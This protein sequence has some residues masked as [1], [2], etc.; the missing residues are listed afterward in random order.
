[1]KDSFNLT[2]E[3]TTLPC[4]VIFT[5]VAGTG[6][7]YRL[8]QLAKHYTDMLQAVDADQMGKTLVQTLSWR[9]VIALVF[10]HK[11]KQGQELLKVA[12]IVAN[13]F[14]QYKAMVNDREENL[15]QTAW[16]T[17][18]KYAHTDKQSAYQQSIQA[19]FAK[20][21]SSHWYLLS[22]SLPLL[23][24]LQIQLDN[25]LNSVASC[26][27]HE[28]CRYVM[29]SFHQAYGYDEFVEGI[30]PSI[31][32]DGK[33]HYGIQA[34][35]FVRLCEQAQQDPTHRYAMLI[36]EIN[37]ANV[38][39]VFGEL[40]S[41][42]EPSKRIGQPQAMQVNLAYSGRLFGVPNNVDIYATMNVQDR[43]LIAL[44]TA[45]RRR[46]EFVELLP[47]SQQLPCIDNAYD[48]QSI[49][50]AKILDGLNIRLLQHVGEQS[51]LGQAYFYGIDSVDKLLVVMVKQVLPQLLTD[52][53]YAQLTQ[54]LNLSKV[55]WL[56][57]TVDIIRDK[58]T[59]QHQ[60]ELSQNGFFNEFNESSLHIHPEITKTISWLTNVSQQNLA[61]KHK[62]KFLQSVTWQ[63]LYP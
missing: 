8:Q 21:S 24:D 7:T 2:A 1:M 56:V 44:D 55:P 13:P 12:D 20:D 32:D 15:E 4:N 14:F 3:L 11:L 47:N 54:V 52:L 37:R 39:Q 53:S 23:T 35:A 61:K 42:I 57:P 49:D 9:E 48:H 10:L 33:M 18:G 22:D 41:L 31:D 34:G 58:I 45:L 16:T 51:L 62:G 5:G 27:Q 6:K 60:S 38:V 40:L 30:R 17:L 46:F 63:S 50:L 26:H 59:N 25:Y 28:R 19:Y 29:V 43:S 36:D